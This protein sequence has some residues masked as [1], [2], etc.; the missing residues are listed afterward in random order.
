NFKACVAICEERLRNFPN[1]VNA[2][3]AYA[4]CCRTEYLLKYGLIPQL[5][6]KLQTVVSCLQQQAPH[7][8]YTHL[9]AAF[10]YMLD[11]DYPA[12]IQ[13]LEKSQEL[14]A[15]DTHLNIL[16]G[17]MYMALDQWELGSQ[18]VQDCINTSPIYP[19][20]YHVPLCIYYYR[21]GKYLD[22]IQAAKNIKFKHLW[23]PMLRSALYSCN[24]AHERSSLEYQNLLLD[25]PDLEKKQQSLTAGF[26]YKSQAVI[27]K[28]WEHLPKPR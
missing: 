6:D 11:E 16:V 5:K 27:S 1:D 13:A 2:L 7:N 19:D 9:Y 23:G 3:I 18:Y 20:W 14:N 12:A 21:A 24:D 22:A 25:Y 28:I 17:M 15:L 8:A 4:D 26:T 10:S